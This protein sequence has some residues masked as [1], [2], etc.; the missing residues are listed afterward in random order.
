MFDDVP[1]LTCAGIGIGATV[2]YLYFEKTAWAT[3]NGVLGEFSADLKIYLEENKGVKRKSQ[4]VDYEIRTKLDGVIEG[5]NEVLCPFFSKM[6]RVRGKKYLGNFRKKDRKLDL[7]DAG[8]IAKRM[9]K[10][11]GKN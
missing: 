6:R 5:M 2:G 7:K 10:M 1:Y 4:E 8:K 3:M 9:N 11:V